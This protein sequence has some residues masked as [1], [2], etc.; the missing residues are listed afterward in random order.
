MTSM[1]KLLP[2][3][4]A[5][6]LVVALPVRAASPKKPAQ[7]AP[8]F[9]ADLS[10]IPIKH[11]ALCPSPSKG[12]CVI[13]K[14]VGMRYRVLSTGADLQDMGDYWIVDFSKSK[15]AGTGRELLRILGENGDL[16]DIEVHFPRPPVV[17]VKP[18][19]KP[20]A[21]V[22]EPVKEPAGESAP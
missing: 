16:Q 3:C 5:S 19:A 14:P 13:K 22:K 15:D 12:L 20:V 4:L 2:A 10:P 21:A 18:A 1:K 7:R 9:V 6:F 17:K 8:A 11:G